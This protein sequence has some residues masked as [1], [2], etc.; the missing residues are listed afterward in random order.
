MFTQISQD[1]KISEDNILS[2]I[3]S[4]LD[5]NAPTTSM[6]P[7]PLVSTKASFVESSKKDAQNYFKSLSS[8]VKKSNTDL[9]SNKGAVTPKQD[10]VSIEYTLFSIIMLVACIRVFLCGNL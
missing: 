2:D 3:M 8:A 7:K 6:K 9:F 4:D 10:V 1:I 5:G